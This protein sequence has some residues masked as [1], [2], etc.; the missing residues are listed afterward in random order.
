VLRRLQNEGPSVQ[1]TTADAAEI[2]RIQTLLDRQQRQVHKKL[3]LLNHR[4]RRPID[5]VPFGETSPK[6]IWEKMYAYRS[7]VAHGDFVDFRTDTELR[8]LNGAEDALT[9]VKSTTK[10]VILQAIDEPQLLADLR[11]C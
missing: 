3:A 8:A 2:A 1:L 11:D 7:R 5:Y 9:L 10:A 4:F 6:K